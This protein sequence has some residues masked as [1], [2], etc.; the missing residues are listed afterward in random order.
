MTMYKSETKH[1]SLSNQFVVKLFTRKEQDRQRR[2]RPYRRPACQQHQ[3]TWQLGQR[4][5]RWLT[6]EPRQ[7]SWRQQPLG[8]RKQRR[9]RR[10]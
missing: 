3:S 7:R 1:C 4:R 6:T 9:G 5:F 10:Q 2:E 8:S